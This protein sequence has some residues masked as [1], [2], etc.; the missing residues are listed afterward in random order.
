[1]VE[2]QINLVDDVEPKYLFQLGTER[3]KHARHAQV[4]SAEEHEQAVA[5]R[6][7]SI[8]H[9]IGCLRG[10]T[11]RLFKGEVVRAIQPLQRLLQI[12]RCEV[13]RRSSSTS[14][15]AS[16]ASSDCSLVESM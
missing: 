3:L 2:Q 8:A 5:A 4:E 1:M 6:P 13:I 9:F 11:E 7:G 10:L 12:D 16:S 14:V 15:E